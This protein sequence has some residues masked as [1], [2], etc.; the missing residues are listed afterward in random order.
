MKVA[1]DVE[2]LKI[3]M[4]VCELDRPWRETPFLFQGF[5]IRSPDEIEQLRR[6]CRTVYVL[7]GEAARNVAIRRDREG[8]TAYSTVP[9]P[10]H[11]RSLKV[12][13]EVFKINNRPGDEPRYPDRTSMA[14]EAALA[15]NVFSETRLLVQEIMYD[16]KLGRS[17]N[18]SGARQSVRNMTDS[19][20]RNPDA[21]MCFAWLQRKDEYT[22]LHGLRVSVLALAFGRHLG[23]GREQLEAL[24]VGALLHD[25]GMVRVP[26]EILKKTAELTPKEHALVQHHVA[27]GLEIL[28]N[29][30][31]IPRAALEVV[32]NHHERHDG[33]GY[34]RGLRG[35]QIGQFGLIGAIVDHYDAITTDR[36]YRTAVSPHTVLMDMYGWRDTLFRAEL[37]EK[38]IQCLGVYPMGSVV[39]LNTGE[40]GVVAAINRGQRLKP[41]V[42][43]VYR[44]DGRPYPEMP[45]A[46]ITARRTDDGRACEIERVLE[47]AVAGIDPVQFLRRVVAV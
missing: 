6:L 31:H 38:F 25:V 42:M 12:V 35:E 40:I 41:H 20:L 22:A 5:V 37:V 34:P 27:W 47:P 32:A 15:R 4:Y 23:L 11:Y 7:K 46:N 43:L 26:D 8:R 29:S 45:I 21:L 3:G 1:V 16:A 10:P 13:Q 39:Q 28:S 36:D 33:S 18:L 17:L 24:G 2:K 19:V 30:A 14:E 44:A 9:S